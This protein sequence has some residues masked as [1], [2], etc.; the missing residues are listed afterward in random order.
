MFDDLDAMKRE[1][2]VVTAQ[3]LANSGLPAFSAI[4]APERTC[5]RPQLMSKIQGLWTNGMI[6]ASSLLLL[7][8]FAFFNFYFA[9]AFL[10][11]LGPFITYI[12]YSLYK[13]A[14]YL[15]YLDHLS[16]EC[17]AMVQEM[18]NLLVQIKSALQLIQEVELVSR[19]YRIT[20]KLSP[21]ARL[22]QNAQSRRC[23]LVRQAS[24]LALSELLALLRS[25]QKDIPLS[26]EFEMNIMKANE[27]ASEMTISALKVLF[28]NLQFSFAHHLEIII[29]HH[30]SFVKEANEVWKISKIPSLRVI[31]RV[32]VETN[33]ILK[34]TR[35]QI[36]LLQ[37][38][39]LYQDT[40]MSQSTSTENKPSRAQ[41]KAPS[42]VS[43]LLDHLNDLQACISTQQARIALCKDQLQGWSEQPETTL[44][45]LLQTFSKFQSDMSVQLP[46]SV[47]TV[48]NA[49]NRLTR[50][51]EGPQDV[52]ALNLPS[53]K[54]HGEFEAGEAST[55]S[56]VTPSFAEELDLLKAKAVGP[57]VERIYEAEAKNEEEDE[58]V[59]STLTRDQRIALARQAREE[60]RQREAEVFAKLNFVMELKDV[61][62]SRTSLQ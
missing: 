26:S 32:S 62:Q 39:Y 12:L 43:S 60:A 47:S 14:S 59:H 21:I 35:K 52:A 45:E 50:E 40:W 11:V 44:N 18:Q 1:F 23:N 13:E 9:F 48:S 46:H 6:M 51:L 34:L 10:L 24:H 58:I 37:K 41:Q 38:A 22:E 29:V 7:L 57:I 2:I 16:R 27:N 53:A 3:N 36:D 15:Q 8:G 56:S 31:R 42:N 5:E 25:Y 33:E 55:S 4:Q 54:V 28:Q 30:F 49:L 19:G 17:P 20:P 61:L